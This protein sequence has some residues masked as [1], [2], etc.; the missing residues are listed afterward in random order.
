MMIVEA[1]PPDEAHIFWESKWKVN[2]LYSLPKDVGG[3]KKKKT[4]QSL[5]QN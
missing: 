3:G 4:T 2:R 1:E 5:Y